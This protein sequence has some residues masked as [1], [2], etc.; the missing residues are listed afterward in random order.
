M[1]DLYLKI[2]NDYV[3]KNNEDKQLVEL[4]ESWAAKKNQMD[5]EIMKRI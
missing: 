3:R 4:M 5:K 2:Q 1:N